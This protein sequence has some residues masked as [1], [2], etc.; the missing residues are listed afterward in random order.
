MDRPVSTAI[1]NKLLLCISKIGVMKIEI[2]EQSYAVIVGLVIWNYTA[3]DVI[4][5]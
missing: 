1:I 2:Y 5:K 4:K 3:S